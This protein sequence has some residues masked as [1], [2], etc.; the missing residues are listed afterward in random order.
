MLRRWSW[1]GRPHG[2]DTGGR[3]STV[4]GVVT[5]VGKVMLRRWSWD[6][7]L[8]GDDTG[9]R[10]CMVCIVVSQDRV[11][12]A[13]GIM[14]GSWSWITVVTI[15]VL[16]T[17]VFQLVEIYLGKGLELTV[18]HCWGLSG[19][20]FEVIGYNIFRRQP[21][22]C[23]TNGSDTEG[24]TAWSCSLHMRGVWSQESN[25]EKMVFKWQATQW[26]KW[27]QRLYMV[28]VEVSLVSVI[29]V[30]RVIFRRWLWN[31][32]L[33]SCYVGMKDFHGTFEVSQTEP[34]WY[35]KSCT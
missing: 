10:D 22:N 7:R 20:S 33:L 28:I 1:T 19:Q 25:T 31:C 8:L 35:D 16:G 11:L 12:W 3:D 21:W 24:K 29:W 26:W 23:I 14:L 34:C 15:E 32:W 18:N 9:H 2:D 27:G 6:G 13:S 30:G 5:P 4:A 17:Q